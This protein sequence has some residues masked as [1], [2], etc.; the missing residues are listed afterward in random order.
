MIR[1]VAFA[2]SLIL[3]QGAISA[4]SAASAR[5]TGSQALALAAVVAQYSSLLSKH[6]RSLV[7]RLFDGDLNIGSP[8]DQKIS[9]EA[10]AI[11]CRTSNV[12]I[13]AR[14]CRLT[15]G[16]HKRA[17]KGRRAN[18]LNAT[19]TEAGVPSEGAAGSIIAGFSHLACTIDPK[20]IKQQTGGGAECRFD[21]GP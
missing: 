20:E 12:D 4:V 17:L 15:F 1:I 3:G 18:E 9:V 21:T 16:T 11:V 19:A 8:P 7:A 13:T 5:A 14:Y 2:L 10:E 6:D